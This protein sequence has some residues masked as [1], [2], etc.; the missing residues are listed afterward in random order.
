MN[1]QSQP[2]CGN[3]IT[4]ISITNTI[5][6]KIYYGKKCSDA[7]PHKCSY[8]GSGIA[9]HHAYK[10]YGKSAFRKDI[11][12]LCENME[13]MNE[14]EELIVDERVVESDMTYNL[15]GGGATSTIISEGTRKKMGESKRKWLELPGSREKVSAAA[16]A[17]F[18][19]PEY[20][21][22]RRIET[23]ERLKKMTPGEYEQMCKR[24]KKSAQDPE[25]RK[26]ISES[27]KKTMTPEHRK[28]LSD[29]VKRT[30]TPEHRKRLSDIKRLAKEAK[31]DTCCGNS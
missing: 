24:N 9:L 25:T 10:K 1:Q 27:V 7:E 28:R 22:R 13:K 6:G 11:I 15:K 16:T 3:I 30:M 18:S 17:A 20:R 26:R 2:G 4:Y 12:A 29:A 8:R 31:H 19:S 5:N 21:E 23:L 14:L